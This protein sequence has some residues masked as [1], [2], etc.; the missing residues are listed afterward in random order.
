MRN[1]VISAAGSKKWAFFGRNYA[2]KGRSGKIRKTDLDNPL[3]YPH[4]K[5]HS[6]RLNGL[7]SRAVT[8]IHTF[9]QTELATIK[10]PRVRDPTS[11]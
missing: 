11:R 2:P 7:G 1:D 10:D 9:I 5:F 8:Y 6:N 3:I 4:V